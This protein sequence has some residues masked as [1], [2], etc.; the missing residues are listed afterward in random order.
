MLDEYLELIHTNTSQ[1]KTKKRLLSRILNFILAIVVTQFMLSCQA[2]NT[3][4]GAGIGVGTG[5]VI[6]GL[7]GNSSDNTAAGAIIG[8]TVGGAAGA[9]IGRHMDK[10][11]D[12]LS[13][14]LEG[15]TVERIGEGIKITFDSGLMFNFDSYSLTSNTTSNLS[16][17]SS[18]LNKYEDTEILIEGHTDKTGS[19]DYNMTLSKQRGQEVANYLE[20]LNVKSSRIT[21]EGYG[22]LQPISEIDEQ[23]RRVEVA[24]YANNRMKRAA[25]RG[26]L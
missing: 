22:E 2:S 12:E 15:A 8:A 6:G 9:L 18:T 23:N 10:Q 7:I 11:A 17:L 1:M 16:N 4:K 13:A 19:E 21:T 25:K 26:T 3:N 20:Q 24:I 14:D 5:A